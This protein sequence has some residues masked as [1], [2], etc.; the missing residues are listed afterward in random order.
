VK[1][2]L[3][4]RGLPQ[5][6]GR[7][8]K[9]GCAIPCMVIQDH[10]R[11]C[12]PTFFLPLWRVRLAVTYLDDE[13]LDEIDGVALPAHALDL[14]PG[15]VGAARVRHGVAVVPANEPAGT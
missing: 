11:P 9:G 5:T 8:G 15:A 13:F 6:A 14:V 12:W 4:S 1:E 10:P 3:A 2:D 7:I